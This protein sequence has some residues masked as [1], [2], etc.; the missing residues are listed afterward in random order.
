MGVF[1]IFPAEGGE[2]PDS[3]RLLSGACQL[4]LEHAQ[5]LGS[6]PHETVRFMRVAIVLIRLLS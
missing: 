2:N 3:I 4:D 5:H 1:Q 6:Q